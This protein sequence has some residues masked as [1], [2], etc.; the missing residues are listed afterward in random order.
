MYDVN[1]R[2]QKMLKNDKIAGFF[3]IFKAG[4]FRGLV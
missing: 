3:L 4:G 2:Q 1:K